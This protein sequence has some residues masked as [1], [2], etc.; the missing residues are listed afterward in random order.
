MTFGN[1]DPLAVHTVAAAAGRVLRDLAKKRGR[2]VLAEQWR[3]NVIGIALAL[4][5]G[6]LPEKDVQAFKENAQLWAVICM[7]VDRIREV[8]PE[9]NLSELTLLFEVEVSPGAEKLHW[10]K[11]NKVANF[12]K[13]A[14]YDDDHSITEDE[15]DPDRVLLDACSLYVDLTGQLTPEMQVWTAYAVWVKPDR[16]LPKGNGLEL[17]E[18]LVEALRGVPPAKRQVAALDFIRVLKE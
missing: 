11:Y 13:H 14:D 15:A 8:G 17:Q 18:L 4:I 12:L 9:K 7:F 1:E 5:S 16:A 10:A 2:K 3:D 6:D